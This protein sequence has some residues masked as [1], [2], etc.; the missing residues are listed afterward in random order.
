M[1][2]KQDHRGNLP[3]SPRM[4][5]HLTDETTTEVTCLLKC[6]LVLLVFNMDIK[7]IIHE[8]E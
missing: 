1:E 3:L 2:H 6:D 5:K 8:G 7:I 4:P